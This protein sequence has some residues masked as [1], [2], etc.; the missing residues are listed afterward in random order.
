MLLF[1][2]CFQV[3]VV[4]SGNFVILFGLIGVVVVLGSCECFIWLEVMV[5]EDDYLV[6]LLVCIEVL[7]E[8]WLVEVLCICCQ[9]GN[10]IV[11]FVGEVSEMLDEFSLYDV[12]VCCLQQEE[13]V[14][15]L[16]QVLSECYCVVVVSLIEGDV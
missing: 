4:I 16:Q 11:W 7:I 2:F 13:L 8:G 1:V 5:V 12:F 10:V 6:D 14:E 9:C 3:L 15:D